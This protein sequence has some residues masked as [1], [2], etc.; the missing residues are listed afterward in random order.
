MPRRPK[1]Q[2]AQEL[3][4]DTPNAMPARRIKSGGPIDD[5][6]WRELTL[7]ARGVNVLVKA[8]QSKFG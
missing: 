5:D 8:P 4:V 2:A 6:T 7:A 1:Q 3:A